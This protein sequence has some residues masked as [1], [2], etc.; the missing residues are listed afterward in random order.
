M[1]QSQVR[2]AGW[3]LLLLIV[4]TACG[5]DDAGSEADD[6]PLRVL[7]STSVVGQLA[8]EVGGEHVEVDVLIGRGVDPHLYEPSPSDA[9]KMDDADLFLMIGLEF[10][11]YLRDDIEA[12]NSDAEIVVITEG[13][14]LLEAGVHEDDHDDEELHED[15]H[16]D[17]HGAYDPHVW[18]DPL[19]AKQMV[20]NIGDALSAIDPDP[21]MDFA[22]NA[23]MYQERLDQVH[24]EILEL[25]DRIPPEKRKV[26]TNHAAFTYFA[27]R[28]ELEIV[29][30]VFPGVTTEADPSAREIAELNELIEEEDVQAIFS[31]DLIDP[32]IVEQLASDTGIEVVAGLYTGQLGPEDSEAATLDGML[33]ANARA[34]AAALD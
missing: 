26:I 19:R 28:Y 11:D 15:E 10:D 33:L 16:E 34:I 24:A 3:L 13:I 5:G 9:R 31:E 1:N 32:K 7:A 30:T 25:V 14:E 4:V 2:V 22:S 6:G 29:G 18:Q 27:D 12:A 20:A 23:A 8:R 17:D 21:A